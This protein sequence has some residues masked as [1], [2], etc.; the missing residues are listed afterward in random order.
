MNRNLP[1]A[2]AALPILFLLFGLGHA[3]DKKS[4]WPILP[5]DA[6]QKLTARSIKAIE[7]TAK[8]DAARGARERINVEAA[9]LAGYT[10]CTKNPGDDAPASLRGAA[11]AASKLELKKLADFGSSIKTAP[12][13]PASFQAIKVDM[14]DL[15]E[16]FRGKAK[17]GEGLHPDLQ[18]QPKLKNLNGIEALI[19]GWRP[20]KSATTTWPRYRRSCR[21]WRTALP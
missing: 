9:I 4:P 11:F 6:Y 1:S 14:L 15:M 8:S 10:M 18:Y 21:T 17:R 13:A 20:R 12:K 19:S 2:F 5:A 16:I 3:G 7:E